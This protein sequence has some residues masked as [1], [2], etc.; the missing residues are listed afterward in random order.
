[1]VADSKDYVIEIE[2]EYFVEDDLEV[3]IAC[4]YSK[5]NNYNKL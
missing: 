5:T 3:G 1:M 2:A 4:K